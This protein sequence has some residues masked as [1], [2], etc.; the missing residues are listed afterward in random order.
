M[1][2]YQMTN[3]LILAFRREPFEEA[4]EAGDQGGRGGAT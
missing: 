4:E 3:E 2:N 1:Y